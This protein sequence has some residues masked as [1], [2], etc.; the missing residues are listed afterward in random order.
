M[1]MA[2]AY[3]CRFIELRIHENFGLQLTLLSIC[4]Q[5]LIHHLSLFVWFLFLF[6]EISKMCIICKQSLQNEDKLRC[7][8]QGRRAIGERSVSVAMMSKSSKAPKRVDAVL[9]HIEEG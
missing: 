1:T 3:S 9:V 6:A 2:G 4:I 5:L 7:L 8:F